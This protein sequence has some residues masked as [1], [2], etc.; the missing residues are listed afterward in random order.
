MIRSGRRF[1]RSAFWEPGLACRPRRVRGTLSPPST[2]ELEV[3]DL[4]CEGH[5][6]E[7]IAHQLDISEETVKRHLSNIF[8]KLN[9]GSRTELAVTTLKARHALEI[10]EAVRNYACADLQSN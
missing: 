2:R 6:N 5:N 9:V 8:A 1:P 3:I 10:A 7:S 4:I